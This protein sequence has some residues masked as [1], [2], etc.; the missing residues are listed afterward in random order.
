M[1]CKNVIE[2]NLEHLPFFLF[3][4]KVKVGGDACGENNVPK[5]RYLVSTSGPNSTDPCKDKTLKFCIVQGGS[6][7]LV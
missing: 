6:K 2:E 3:K 7:D 1:G 4:V 5:K